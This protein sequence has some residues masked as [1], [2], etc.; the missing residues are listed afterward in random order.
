MPEQITRRNTLRTG[1]AAAGL[2][3]FATDWAVPALADGEYRHPVHRLSEG[4]Q[5][6][7]NPNVANRFLDIRK[8][9]G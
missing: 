4:L 2:L 5:S 6:E 7:R 9:T 1:L 3:A 8:L